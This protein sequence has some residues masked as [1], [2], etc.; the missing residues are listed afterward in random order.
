[1]SSVE[2]SNVFFLCRFS[3]SATMYFSRE[4]IHGKSRRAARTLSLQLS[5]RLRQLYRVSLSRRG[6][7]STSLRI[8][9]LRTSMAGIEFLLIVLP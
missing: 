4:D 2:A 5:C 9:F 7:P 1:M 8:V 3:S 6:S